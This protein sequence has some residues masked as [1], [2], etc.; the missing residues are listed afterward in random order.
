MPVKLAAFIPAKS[1]SKRLENK[2]YKYFF[3]KPIIEWVKNEVKKSEMFNEF[4]ISK[5]INR[6]K[7]LCED[8]VIVEDVL[9]YHIEKGD[10]K[11]DYIC[12]IYPCAYVVTAEHLIN[13]FLKMRDAGKDY[14]YSYGMLNG[15]Y[16]MDAGGFYWCKTNA[17]LRDNI[18]IHKDAL[19]YELPMIDINTFE[20]FLGAKLD[21]CYNHRERFLK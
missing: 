14:C 20:D 7:A 1:N 4:L 17:F 13:S 3:G 18:F 15:D 6:P 21:V 11:A 12:V 9:S 2:N 10:I 5:D 8:G 19:R 16:E